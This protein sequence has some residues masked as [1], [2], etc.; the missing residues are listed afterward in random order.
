MPCTVAVAASAG[1]R[2]DM[3]QRLLNS[4]HAGHGATSGRTVS[5][6]KESS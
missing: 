3:W 5:Q 2:D 6:Q 1:I 4:G